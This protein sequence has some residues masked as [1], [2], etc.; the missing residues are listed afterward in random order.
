MVAPA[1]SVTD[2]VAVL[3]PPAVSSSS[4]P[5][6]N[7]SDVGFSPTT[8]VKSRVVPLIESFWPVMRVA[9]RNGKTSTLTGIGVPSKKVS[10]MSSGPGLKYLPTAGPTIRIRADMDHPSRKPPPWRSAPARARA[11]LVRFPRVPGTL[12]AGKRSFRDQ[13]LRRVE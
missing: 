12:P 1:S 13:S 6:W 4:P 8:P 10:I 11:V 5:R 2:K 9:G 3:I 7:W